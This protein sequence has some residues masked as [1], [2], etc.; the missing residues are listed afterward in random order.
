MG[1]RLI[2]RVYESDLEA[3][4]KPIAAVMALHAH[5]HDEGR[6]VTVF[7]ATVA[8]YLSQHRRKTSRQLSQLRDRGVLVPLTPLQGG[9]G[10]LVEYQLAA[11]AP[12]RKS[13]SLVACFHPKET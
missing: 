13:M 4:L 2:R 6:G 5:D 12:P 10:R 1:L 9:A 7:V 11:A 8:S 3:S